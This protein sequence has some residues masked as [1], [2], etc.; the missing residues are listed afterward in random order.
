MVHVSSSTLSA[1]QTTATVVGASMVLLAVAT[2][3]IWNDETLKT[4]R[5]CEN[6]CKYGTCQ[7]GTCICNNGFFGKFCDIGCPGAA[8][9]I[10]ECNNVG[11]CTFSATTNTATC[12]CEF[13]WLGGD[14]SKECPGRTKAKTINGD[15]T[16]VCNEGGSCVLANDKAVCHCNFGYNG[17][18]CQVTCNGKGQ[19]QKQYLSQNNCK[20]ATSMFSTAYTASNNTMTQFC[21]T[22]TDSYTVNYNVY[23]PSTFNVGGANSAASS[24]YIVYMNSH[25]TATDSCKT[26]AKK[27]YCEKNFP[28]CVNSAYVGDVKLD[29][30][31]STCLAMETACGDNTDNTVCNN[32]IGPSGFCNGQNDASA[33]FSRTGTCSVQPRQSSTVCKAAVTYDTVAG[34]GTNWVEATDNSTSDAINA[35][36]LL[37]TT[38]S[39]ACSEAISTYMCQ[40]S[41]KECVHTGYF[42]ITSYLPCRSTCE[43]V[44]TICGNQTSGVSVDC[45]SLPATDCINPS[46]QQSGHIPNVGCNCN[47]GYFG[48]T[49]LAD[50]PFANE[51]AICSNHGTCSYDPVGGTICN[52]DLAWKGDGC[53]SACPGSSADGSSV[54]NG[55]GTC[56]REA[57]TVGAYCDCDEGW[58]LND[59]CSQAG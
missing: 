13:G 57:G 20:V 51:G 1:L 40:T 59:L 25:P 58:R 56:R 33:Q 17:D 8:T 36:K 10:G 27:Y 35:M 11:N 28:K 55:H 6:N 47:V 24:Q 4:E 22:P 29:V 12:N 26:A 44:N 30:C 54:C 9:S 39:T 21:E 45:S 5:Q 38:P 52:C 32:D 53:E 41:Y 23:A 42:G 34:T 16:T 50:C 49:C 46:I 3:I 7:D 2:V 15:V 19:A 14:C 48:P 43:A 18:A 31:R 37:Y